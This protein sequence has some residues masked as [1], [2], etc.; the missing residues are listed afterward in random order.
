MVKRTIRKYYTYRSM[1]KRLTHVTISY[2]CA[3]LLVS[4]LFGCS[5]QVAPFNLNDEVPLGLGNLVVYKV[6]FGTLEEY[7]APKTYEGSRL[8]DQV[9]KSQFLTNPEH[10]P[11]C[12]LFRYDTSHSSENTEKKRASMAAVSAAQIYTIVDDK[13][14]KYRARLL[15]PKSAAYYQEPGAIGDAE[16]F[17]RVMLE[18]LWEDDRV[19]AFSMPKDSAGLTLLIENPIPQKGQPKIAAVSL[20]R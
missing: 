6:E 18:L 1:F 4:A 9:I 10:V 20:G 17:K 5:K 13:R 16:D 12:V 7:I 8:A 11:V 3:A 2:L 14:V 19:V 15:V